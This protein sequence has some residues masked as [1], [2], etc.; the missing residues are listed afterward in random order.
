M[1]GMDEVRSLIRAEEMTEKREGLG[2]G[3]NE[4]SIEKRLAMRKMRIRGRG[5]PEREGSSSESIHPL[6]H[7]LL[8]EV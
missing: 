5:G 3:G 4:S 6:I 7:V 8:C 2:C 1:A